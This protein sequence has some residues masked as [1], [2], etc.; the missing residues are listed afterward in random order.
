MQKADLSDVEKL[1]SIVESKVD[2]HRLDEIVRLSARDE[3]I[4]AGVYDQ[5]RDMIRSKADRSELDQVF[6]SVSDGKI[7]QE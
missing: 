6:K 2:S 4:S 3:S 7:D 5:L 1:C